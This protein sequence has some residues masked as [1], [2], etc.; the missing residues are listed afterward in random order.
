MIELLDRKSILNLNMAS[1]SIILEVQDAKYNPIHN[2][3]E[4]GEMY[5]D[6]SEKPRFV[7]Q[8][9]CGKWNKE[10]QM[11]FDQIRDKV[12]V[13]LIK[14]IEERVFTFPEAEI[15]QYLDKLGSGLECL[16]KQLHWQSTIFLLDYPTPWLSQNNDNELVIK[17]LDYLR[18][19]RVIDDFT[20]G[21]K[22][23]RHSFFPF[24][25]NNMFKITII[26]FVIFFLNFHARS[27]ANNT[28]AAMF[29][30]GFGMVTSSIGAII[31]KSKEHQTWP[32]VR[33]ALWQGALGGAVT[34][35][36]KHLIQISA[37]KQNWRYVWPAKILNNAGASIKEN[38]SLNRDFWEQW[39]FHIG[40]NRIEFHIKDK[41][42]IQYKTLPATFMSTIYALTVADFDWNTSLRFGQFYFLSNDSRFQQNNVYATTYS[43][44]VVQSKYYK[45]F[46]DE[47]RYFRTQLHE[48]IHLFAQNDFRVFNTYLDPVWKKCFERNRVVKFIYK[49]TYPE[50][51]TYFLLAPLY[52]IEK[53][54]ANTYY[55]NFFEYE[56]GYY[57]NTL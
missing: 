45:S 30:I 13:E 25:I 31:N 5:M 57:S 32:I 55:D 56:A 1:A 19:I 28:E 38:A 23:K 39:N 36:S 46:I 20:G 17:A 43:G 7:S 50:F 29:N 52:W 24:S 42:K 47:E 41:R 18:S 9:K 22:A 33:K 48:N 21:F 27:Q 40:F 34:Y 37:E 12:E 6:D 14:F 53:K 26:V 3:N 16:N 10:E 49:Y 4:L 11:E 35:G 54:T 44:L 15:E 2:Q 8:E 51:S